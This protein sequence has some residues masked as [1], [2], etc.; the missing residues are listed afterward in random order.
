[1]FIF[2]Y[3]NPAQRRAIFTPKK[4]DKLR[5]IPTQLTNCVNSFSVVME[6]ERSTMQSFAK[7]SGACG[8]LRKIV[9]SKA[10]EH[11]FQTRHC[12]QSSVFR[13]SSGWA[14]SCGG[15][16]SR[17]LL[18][19]DVGEVPEHERLQAVARLKACECILPTHHN[20]PTDGP[21]ECLR[22]SWRVKWIFCF[23]I[24]AFH[25]L[26]SSYLQFEIFEAFQII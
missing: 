1:M 20:S 8:C 18:S 7:P 22:S 25:N 2:F 3:A 15:G 17:K 14:S 23:N 10:W 4:S 5:K 12:F 21:I 24:F 11:S 9:R 16:S 6:G 19:N 13:N 26:R